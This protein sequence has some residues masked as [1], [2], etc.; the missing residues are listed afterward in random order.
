[1]LL[2]LDIGMMF[3]IGP[4]LVIRNRLNDV[5]SA[6]DVDRFACDEVRPLGA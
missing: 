4:Y 2:A 5:Q 6:V 1:M 3:L